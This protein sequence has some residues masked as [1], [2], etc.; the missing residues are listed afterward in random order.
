MYFIA[1]DALEPADLE[2]L[3]CVLGDILRERKL[4]AHDPKVEL[5]AHEIVSLWNAGFR[6]AEEMKA[7]LNP[8]LL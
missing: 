5:I 4:D 1:F 7:I 6:G 2:L 8:H 3:E